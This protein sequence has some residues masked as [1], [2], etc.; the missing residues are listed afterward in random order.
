MKDGG[1]T[2]KVLQTLCLLNIA[3]TMHVSIEYALSVQPQ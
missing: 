2:K 3:E 1:W